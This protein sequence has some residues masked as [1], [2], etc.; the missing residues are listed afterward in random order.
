[1]DYNTVIGQEFG[2]LTVLSIS[3]AD[4]NGRKILRCKCRCGDIVD[5][6]A[7]NVT[8]GKTLSCGKCGY[9]KQRVQEACCRD[10]R[11]IKFGKLTPLYPTGDSSYN[12]VVWHCKCDCGNE[13]DVP[14]NYFSLRHISCGKCGYRFDRIRETHQK[15]F[16]ADERRLAN[17]IFNNMRT[18]CYNPNVPAYADYGGR[19]IYICDEWL[20]DKLEFVKWSLA[21]GYRRGLTIDR[22]DNDG[23]YAPWN[24]RWVDAMDQSHNKRNNRHVEVLGYVKTIAEWHRLS[25]IPLSTLYSWSDNKIVTM[26]TFL[27]RKLKAEGRLPDDIVC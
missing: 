26:L 25:G 20:H 18:R 17:E 22:I 14:S 8:H 3:G 2:W 1:M 13:V 6:S 24:C 15:Y 4:D 16:S 19:G 21:H 11:G 10:Y 5:V 27:F 23:P 7:Y 12:N 9:H